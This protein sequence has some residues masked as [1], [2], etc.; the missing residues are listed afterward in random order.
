MA[1]LA[2]PEIIFRHEGEALINPEAAEAVQAVSGFFQC[3]TVESADGAF[4]RVYS[5]AGQLD[6]GFRQ[7]VSVLLCYQHLARAQDHRIGSG[8]DGVACI[9]EGRISEA[10]HA[11]SGATSLP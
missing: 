9:S 4:A 3:L 1:D 8:P 6:F 2:G 10:S 11:A 5:A 7:A